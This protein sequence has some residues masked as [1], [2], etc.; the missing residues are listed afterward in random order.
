MNP[1][2]YLF[3]CKYPSLKHQHKIAMSAL[4]LLSIELKAIELNLEPGVG[5]D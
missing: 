3:C 4:S 1:A 5:D 2:S